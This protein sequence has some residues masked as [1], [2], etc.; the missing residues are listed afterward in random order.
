SQ[1][2]WKE[3]D[4]DVKK[5]GKMVELEGC[6]KEPG[7]LLSRGAM[8]QRNCDPRGIHYH[9]SSRGACNEGS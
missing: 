1:K 4:G 6:K 2:Q 8:R 5:V 9:T 3:S 7:F